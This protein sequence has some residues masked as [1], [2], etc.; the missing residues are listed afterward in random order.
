MS[1]TPQY[2]DVAEA[3]AT[4]EWTTMR[5]ELMDTAH[6]AALMMESVVKFTA[7][8]FARELSGY[9]E[10]E[11]RAERAEAALGRIDSRARIGQDSTPVAAL[12]ALASIRKTIA[13]LRDAAP[14]EECPKC[15]SM[16]CWC[17][18]EE[19]KCIR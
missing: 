2:E 13:A 14:A 12:A 10:R 8:M 19:G 6:D 1:E 7:E 15:K 16:P 5:E 17:G 3:L 9:R 11:A 18:A 4:A